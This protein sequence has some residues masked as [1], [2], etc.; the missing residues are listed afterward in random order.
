MRN[1]ICDDKDCPGAKRLATEAATA[2]C[3]RYFMG[4]GLNLN[5]NDATAAANG[6]ENMKKQLSSL[7]MGQNLQALIAAGDLNHHLLL[8]RQQHKNDVSMEEIENDLEDE[9]IEIGEI[10]DD[11]EDGE[12]DGIHSSTS[13]ESAIMT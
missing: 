11:D 13:N 6:M 7:L 4:A 10:D 1:H 9:E 3:S 8:P 5:G 2:L 12:D